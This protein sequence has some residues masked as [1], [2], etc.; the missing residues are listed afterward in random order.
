[1][2]R[3]LKKSK[4]IKNILIFIIYAIIK[5]INVNNILRLTGYNDDIK[6]VLFLLISSFIQRKM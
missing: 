2:K 4:K 5:K 1:M 3:F 6:R